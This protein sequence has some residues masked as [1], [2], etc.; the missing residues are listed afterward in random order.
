MTG[1]G[2]DHGGLRV[3][4]SEAQVVFLVLDPGPLVGKGPHGFGSSYKEGRGNRWRVSDRHKGRSLGGNSGTADCPSGSAMLRH[5]LLSRLRLSEGSEF[6]PH[7]SQ[8]KQ[9]VITVLQAVFEVSGSPL[10]PH[11]PLAG[12]TAM[13]NFCPWAKEMSVRDTWAHL[14]LWTSSLLALQTCLPLCPSTSSESSGSS[15]APTCQSFIILGIVEGIHNMK[16]T[17]VTVFKCRVQCIK[18]GVYTAMQPPPHPC[19][20]LFPPAA[21]TF[22]DTTCSALPSAPGDF[23]SPFYAHEFERSSYTDPRDRLISYARCL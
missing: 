6:Q 3:G 18:H 14:T 11:P 19:P 4:P 13:E 12:L 8:G 7:G 10:Q 2:K 15:T 9:F 21:W 22:L 5:S 17:I 23:H 16:V 1:R 20:E